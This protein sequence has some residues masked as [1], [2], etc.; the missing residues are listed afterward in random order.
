MA[1]L[2]LGR[3]AYARFYAG[4]P[5]IKL[6]NRFF[7]EDPS[8][9][10]DGV[11]LLS[12]PGSSLLNGFGSG[13]IRSIWSQEGTFNGDLFVVSG[14]K[15][16]RYSKAG[17]K[18]LL[19]GTITGSGRV[20]MDGTRDFVFVADGASLQYY[21]G[22]GN[23][24]TG[25]LTTTGVFSDAETVTIGLVTYTF[26]TVLGGANSVL[27][28]VD[29][30]ET[31]DNLAA[32]VVKGPGEGSV[33][34]TG[35]VANPLA[36]AEKTA[37]DAVTFT[38]VSAGTAG[39]TVAT[40]ETCA[41]ASFAAATLTGGV[42]NALNGIV[43]PDDIGIVSLAVIAG[44][45]M[46]AVA[47]SQRIYFIRPGEV[48]IDP[49]DFFAAERKPDEAVAL[50]VLGDSLWIFGETTTE[51]WYVS[52]VGTIPFARQQGLAFSRGIVPGTQVLVGDQIIVVG[53][54]GVVYSV[55]G[56]LQRLSTHGI[57]EQIRVAR[58]AERAN[59]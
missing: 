29:A 2:P 42:A 6:E 12:R 3:G 56:G 23:F 5:E 40:T 14:D 16:F 1:S 11:A 39:N 58:E 45:V 33:Y 52:G 17:V 49:L 31:L 21:N 22:I 46:L 35:T 26:N 25:V 53:D 10:V 32:A 8:N 7:E 51:T 13:V 18:T 24:A 37:A 27:I 34:G 48:V 57:E 15:L 47:N 59:A 50:M 44:F 4:E 41:N 55:S 28:G 43:T 54:N 36:K 30:D 9:R 38:A 20:Q 19:P